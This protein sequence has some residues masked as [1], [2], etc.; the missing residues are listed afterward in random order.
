MP[1]LRVI[2]WPKTA[3]FAVAAMFAAVIL[4]A[5]SN[6]H[7]ARVAT[8][9]EDSAQCRFDGEAEISSVNDRIDL[10]TARGLAASV[11]ND[12]AGVRE[13]L[14]HIDKHSDE[15]ER[16]VNNRRTILRECDD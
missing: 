15:F 16:M 9:I 7:I 5:A 2:G 13:A 4:L 8:I 10:W 12:H 3:T 6:L 11:R 14:T 1:E